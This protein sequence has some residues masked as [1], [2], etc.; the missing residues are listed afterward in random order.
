M[1]NSKLKLEE[2]MLIVG[3]HRI[4]SEMD[5]ETKR[6]AKKHHLSMGQFMVLEALDHKGRLTVGQVKEFA[7]SSDGTIPVITGN[8]EKMGYITKTQD[9]K[10]KRKFWLEITEE[11]RKTV[12][13]MYPENNEM[14]KKQLS[15]WSEEDKKTLRHMIG[16]YNKH[17]LNA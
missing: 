3:L 16:E 5:K 12:A 17:I 4:V 6:I 9:E 7:L 15:F 14:L 2:S 1:S 10:D 13:Q 11:G 8:L